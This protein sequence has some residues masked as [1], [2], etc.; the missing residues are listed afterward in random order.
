MDVLVDLAEHAGD[1]RSKRRLLHA[2]WRD[3]FVSDDVLTH[4]I[5]E[6]R[7]AFA[8]DA[9]DPRFIRTVPRKGYMLVAEV[10]WPRPDAPSDERFPYRLGEKLGAGAMGEVYKAEDTRL[11]RTVALK[12]L[13]RE[14]AADHA[15]KDR[16]LREA[17]AAAALDHP[18]IGVVHDLGE[19]P[20][21]RMFIAM[22]YY[23]G[24]SLKERLA[25]GPLPVEE[26]VELARQIA[27]GLA[28]AHG[29]G[30]VHRDIKPAN[31]MLSE[32]SQVKVVD[33][34]LARGAG[35]T[36]LTTLGSTVGT[37]LYMSPEQARGDEVD[38]RSDLW[39]LG[40]TLFEMVS[41]TQPFR[42]GDIQAV[43]YAVLN[44]EP[45]E[46]S[47]VASDL[48]PGL[49]AVVHRCLEKDPDERYQE[50]SALAEDLSALLAGR[51]PI[52]GF[53]HE[54]SPYPGLAPFTEETASFFFGREQEVEALWKKVE[55]RKLLALIG[56]SG[57]GKTSFV[58]AGVIPARPEGWRC[59]ACTPKSDP[60]V[61]LGQALAPE[62]ARDPEALRELLRF[63]QPEAA[64][65]ML[66]SWRR[67]FPE[68]L[69]IVDQFEELFTL[70]PS[71]V[72]ASF[73]ELLAR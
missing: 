33:F 16:F 41:G 46:L 55:Q 14:L 61:S 47:S 54:K 6:L 40:V 32:D 73:A 7:R 50:A 19:S 52:A 37:A 29:R 49:E 57:A 51:R 64:F 21:R 23:R 72:Q 59:L 68:A 30:I 48:P 8:D 65:S 62:L 27:E 2:V 5:W 66:S 70:S 35:D 11:R 44:E 45:V 67:R 42:G 10:I 38:P 15:A 18:H 31:V 34:G 53:G 25:E 58:R 71:E 39:S 28:A 20:D 13:P 24:E 60:F 9:K 1:V 26:A 56:P 4:A 69:I 63:H 3:A 12:F 22:A 43:L 36:T 17:R